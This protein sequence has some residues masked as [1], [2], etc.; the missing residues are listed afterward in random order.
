MILAFFC[1]P[2]AGKKARASVW[3]SIDLLTDASVAT[4]L[5][6]VLGAR[7]VFILQ[8]MPYYLAHKDELFLFSFRD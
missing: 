6:G 7:V 4:L 5:W 1:C 8:D 3:G 2:L